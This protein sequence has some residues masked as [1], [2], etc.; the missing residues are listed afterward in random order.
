M[1][2]SHGLLVSPAGSRDA[3]DPASRR[4]EESCLAAEPSECAAY[5]PHSCD[6][7][8]IGSGTAAEVIDSL[9]ELRTEVD[10]AI[11]Y[12]TEGRPA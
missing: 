10:A 8:I 5:L 11:A 3:Y 2:N 7:W 12:L 9:L 1:S 6:E 4:R